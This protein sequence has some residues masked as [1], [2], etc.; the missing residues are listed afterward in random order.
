MRHR[1]VWL[2]LGVGLVVSVAG[3]AGVPTSPGGVKLGGAYALGAMQPVHFEAR[4]DGGGAIAVFE[5]GA[6]LVVQRLAFADSVPLPSKAATITAPNNQTAKLA[7]AVEDKAGNVFVAYAGPATCAVKVDASGSILFDVSLPGL[8]CAAIAPDEAGGFYSASFAPAVSPVFALNRG[9]TR[10]AHYDAKG[11]PTW[12]AIGAEDVTYVPSCAV[13]AT[14]SGAMAAFTLAVGNKI[15]PGDVRMIAVTSAGAVAGQTTGLAL[16]S[17]ILAHAGAVYALPDGTA[18][19]RA[20]LNTG[21]WFV[22]YDKAAR[23]IGGAK[24]GWSS[25]A[26][27]QAPDGSLAVARGTSPHEVEVTRWTPSA[28]GL[29]TSVTTVDATSGPKQTIARVVWAGS[30]FVV[31]GDQEGK[32][33]V[34]GVLAPD[35][36]KLGTFSTGAGALWSPSIRGAAADGNHFAI[37]EVDAAK[38]ARLAAGSYAL[39]GAVPPLTPKKP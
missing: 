30:R 37:V 12:E 26:I 21:A 28:G 8:G 35:G 22:R 5:N 16:P 18:V 33:P 39:G 13:A 38:Q 20:D 27:G 19:A 11:A 15:G 4:R 36:A 17:P 24:Y 25:Y 2:G 9:R 6:S 23:V 1:G 32:Y 7:Q 10:V 3:A 31:L 29:A 34:F 14:P